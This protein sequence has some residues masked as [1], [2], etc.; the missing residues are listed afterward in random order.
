M[1]V[2]S[3]LTRS[4]DSRWWLS[5]QR[6]CMDARSRSRTEKLNY[7][8]VTLIDEYGVAVTASSLGTSGPIDLSYPAYIPIQHQKLVEAGVELGH[9]FNTDA[10]SGNNTGTLVP[11]RETSEF[12]YLD[13]ITGKTKLTIIIHA[14][15]S[16]INFKT[17]GSEVKAT[18]VQLSS[19]DGTE[20]TATLT[21][22]GNSEILS[23]LGID[24]VLDLPGVGENYED[25][26]LTLLTYALKDGF[27]SFDALQ[28]NSTLLAEVRGYFSAAREA[29]SFV[30]QTALLPLGQG[31]LTFAQA[32][33]DFEPIGQ[34]LNTSE[35]D[36]A[37]QLFETKPDSIP[38]DQFDIIKDQVFSDVPQVEYLLVPQ[39]SLT[40]SPDVL[41]ASTST[42]RQSTIIPNRPNFLEA[43]WDR[44][45]LAKA[46][47]Y[48]RKLLQTHAL[49]EVLVSEE[50]Y[51]GASVQTE[52]QWIQYVKEGVNAGYHSIGSASMMPQEK[53]G[54]V[55]ASLKVYGT[56]NVRVVDLSAMPLHISAHTQSAAYAF[57]EMAADL[58]IA[59]S[60][61]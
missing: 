28:Y 40:R 17:K 59:E 25:H 39:I 33:V 57:G 12:A 27:L 46:S 13:T 22:V 43:E 15:V 23:S 60:R 52:D 24:V 8:S 49:Q 3:P 58:I 56:R 26:T 16:K 36:H 48:G 51:P 37:K 61:T 54:V 20:Y 50:T 38:Q 18:G 4:P 53:N 11:I 2:L 21:S 9:T 41:P 35:I 19:P 31:W 30:Q 42:P 34:I 55:D 1:S 7:P 29:D 10:Y 5:R 32:V 44:W 47:A 14:T 6:P 45:F